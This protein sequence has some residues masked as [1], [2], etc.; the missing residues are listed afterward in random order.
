IVGL[1]DAYR[2]QGHL[3]AKLDPLGASRDAHP[4]LEPAVFGLGSWDPKRRIS[5]GNYRGGSEG[6]L[7]ELIDSLRRTYSGTFAAE[8]MEIRDK[9]RRDWLVER[10]EPFENRPAL[11]NEERLRTLTQLIAAERFEEFLHKRFLGVYRFS[12]EG[13]ES[14][15]PIMDTL[16]EGASELGAD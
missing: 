12:L 1:V 7:A 13:G 15:I 2:S 4:L 6:T 14:L 10:M 3:L 8:F 5:F 9:E 16:I 11:S